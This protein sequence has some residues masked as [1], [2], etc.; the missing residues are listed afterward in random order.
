[1][2]YS[3]RVVSGVDFF[4][5]FVF[6][7]AFNL[8]FLVQ[9]YFSHEQ[10]FLAFPRAIVTNSHTK[11]AKIPRKSHYSSFQRH[12]LSQ[13]RSFPRPTHERVGLFRISRSLFSLSSPR[14]FRRTGAASRVVK[15]ERILYI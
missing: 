5:F 13:S 2:D 14:S 1:M 10:S 9:K 7:R 6:L 11:E 12:P 15:E 3:F 8:S 4:V